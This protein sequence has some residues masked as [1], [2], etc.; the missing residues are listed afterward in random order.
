MSFIIKQNISGIVLLLGHLA[1][2]GVKQVGQ[3]VKS[4]HS[5]DRNGKPCQR[6]R[7]CQQ[8]NNEQLAAAAMV[9]TS[10]QENKKEL[11]EVGFRQV[12]HLVA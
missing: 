5:V 1:H 11:M 2:S 3:R 12:N 9:K 4:T 10:G 7:C 8:K 6:D